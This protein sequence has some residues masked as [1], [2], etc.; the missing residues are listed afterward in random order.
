[1][2]KT[3]LLALALIAVAP[4]AVEAQENILDKL[5][6]KSR[7]LVNL[8][9]Q[10]KTCRM[11]DPIT[12]D[13]G[14]ELVPPLLFCTY[15]L[16]GL[17]FRTREPYPFLAQVDPSH[18]VDV[19]EVR[20]GSGYYLAFSGGEW[21]EVWDRNDPSLLVNASINRITGE[22]REFLPSEGRGN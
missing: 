20:P 7:E 13:A 22:I 10:G 4:V 2:K 18:A 9:H 16:P 11:T 1:M 5:R 12:N 19:F 15:M 3:L 14:D 6:A 17:N 21:F 8:L